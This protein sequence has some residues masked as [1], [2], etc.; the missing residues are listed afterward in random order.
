MTP[1]A[2]LEWLNNIYSAFDEILEN[3]DLYKV[4]I[5]GDAYYVVGGCP[6]VLSNRQ[7]LDLRLLPFLHFVRILLTI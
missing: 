5:I 6:G 1:S 7:V 3:Y 4:E 2:L